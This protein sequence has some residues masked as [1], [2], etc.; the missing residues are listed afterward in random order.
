[1][2]L[3]IHVL[4][5]KIKTAV[6]GLLIDFHAHNDMGMAAANAITAFESG[7]HCA[8]LI[9]NPMAFQP[10]LPGISDGKVSHLFW[11]VTAA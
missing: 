10:F 8:G 7:I 3:V 1:M 2:P 5:K 6:P 4:I 9:E 11:D